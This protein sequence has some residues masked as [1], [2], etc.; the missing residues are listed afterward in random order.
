MFSSF[1]HKHPL[2]LDPRQ[3]QTNEVKLRYLNF[4]TNPIRHSLS[5]VGKTVVPFQDTLVSYQ[6]QIYGELVG[7]LLMGRDT[8]SLYLIGWIKGSAHS[9]LVSFINIIPLLYS[10]LI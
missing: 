4:D 8:S 6:L 7:L 2:L 10:W 5:K 9:H 3:A 1:S